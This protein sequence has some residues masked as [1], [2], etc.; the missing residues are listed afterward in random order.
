MVAE[1]ILGE[2]FIFMS[3]DERDVVP[4]DFR[5]FV[6][7]HNWE[8]PVAMAELAEYVDDAAAQAYRH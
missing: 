7:Q 2:T 6:M 8:D 3:P 5:R 1:L 4:T